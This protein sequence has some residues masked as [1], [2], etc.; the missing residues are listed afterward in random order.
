MPW[1][2]EVST[3][4]SRLAAILIT[5]LPG[6]HKFYLVFGF[7]VAVKPGRGPIRQSVGTADVYAAP[8]TLSV[9]RRTRLREFNYG[10][11]AKHRAFCS[12]QTRK[13]IMHH[14]A[15]MTLSLQKSIMRRKMCQVNNL[16][17]SITSNAYYV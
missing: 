13:I 2:N 7:A 1:R 16:F 3:S 11:R 10:V 8:P 12:F 9:K 14:A 6:A 4:N 15:S 17:F 5:V